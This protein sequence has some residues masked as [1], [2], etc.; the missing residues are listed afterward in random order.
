ML[1]E[2][3]ELDT[4]YPFSFEISANHYIYFHQLLYAFENDDNCHD[5]DDDHDDDIGDGDDRNM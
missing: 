4:F 3:I 2:A 1:I 5:D